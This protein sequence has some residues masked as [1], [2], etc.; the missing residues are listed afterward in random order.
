MTAFIHQEIFKKKIGTITRK[1][2]IR[3][4]IFHLINEYIHFIEQPNINLP[5]GI[6]IP[7]GHVFKFLLYG[8]GV[9]KYQCATNETT[10]AKFWAFVGPSAYLINDI[11]KEKFKKE[12]RVAYHFFQ[13]KPVNGGRPTWKSIIESDKSLVITAVRSQAPSPDDPAKN[14]PWLVTQATHNE[15]PGAF[16]DVTYILRIATY[17]GIAPPASDCGTKY[18][19]GQELS[20]YYTT[21]YCSETGNSSSSIGRKNSDGHL[22]AEELLTRLEL[23]GVC[24]ECLRPKTG[25]FWCQPYQHK[26]IDGFLKSILLSAK[27]Y[28]DFAQ[29]IP[30]NRLKNIKFLSKG[31][32]STVYTA[33]WL[34]GW[35]LEWNRI[36]KCWSRSGERTV[37]MKVL[38][39]S[40]NANEEY[41]NN[42]I[43]PLFE[44]KFGV[45]RYYGISQEPK[46]GNY[47]LIMDY[48][49]LGNL[50]DYYT[51]NQ[52]NHNRHQPQVNG[53]TTT[54]PLNDTATTNRKRAS[55]QSNS[56]YTSKLLDFSN[57]PKPM[58]APVDPED[59]E[60]N[61]Q[62]KLL[63]ERSD[64]EK[65]QHSQKRY[66]KGSRYDSKMVA[67]D[68]NDL[69]E[70]I[71]IELLN[72]NDK[73]DNNY[74]NNENYKN[75]NFNYYYKKSG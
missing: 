68:Y 65:S 62:T 50:Y 72:N 44:S 58:N 39:N 73:D 13:E 25:W 59:P 52:Y 16:S 40:V 14:V 1:Y 7:E 46:T 9:Q 35:I 11:K 32:F 69:N 63:L 31:G 6:K 56:I 37:I 33:V 34:D 27:S 61:D 18:K 19:E 48:A 47:I 38:E 28:R 74:K 26:L 22:I 75:D 8:A 36:D 15:G 60:G 67:E 21:Q 55:F 23:Y 4:F 42:K 49:K 41:L 43:R 20:I 57:L 24:K 45:I 53:S 66:T 3:E 29:W 30:F 12:Y 64:S 71:Y 5:E 70:S 2:Q 51:C 54:S 17:G 10:K